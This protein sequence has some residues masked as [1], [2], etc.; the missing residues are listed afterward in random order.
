MTPFKKLLDDKKLGLVAAVNLPFL[1]NEEQ[2]LVPDVM[3]SQNCKMKPKAATELRGKSGTLSED[4]AKGI[5]E[6]VNKK[7]K[8]GQYQQTVR[9]CL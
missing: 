7:M 6:G 1:S 8:K 9:S 5:L 3:D 4:Y 2:Q